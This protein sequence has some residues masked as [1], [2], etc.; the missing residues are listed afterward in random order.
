MRYANSLKN[1]NGALGLNFNFNKCASPNFWNS[2]R[3]K[4]G[5]N[6]CYKKR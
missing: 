2:L 5:K 6:D 4:V 3:F 1:P